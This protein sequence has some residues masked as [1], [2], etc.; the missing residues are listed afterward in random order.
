MENLHLASV[1]RAISGR[2]RASG[3]IVAFRRWEYLAAFARFDRIP[4]SRTTRETNA[5]HTET[6]VAEIIK[7]KIHCSFL[8]LIALFSLHGIP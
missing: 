8:K 6:H 4:I 5:S 3:D 1:E 2:G 7:R